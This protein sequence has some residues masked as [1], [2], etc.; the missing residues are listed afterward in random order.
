M[1]ALASAAAATNRRNSVPDRSCSTNAGNRRFTGVSC[2]RHTSG[3]NDPNESA[4][5]PA[6]AGASPRSLATSYPTVATTIPL[7][8]SAK[9]SRRVRGIF[10]NLLLLELLG[11]GPFIRPVAESSRALAHRC[12]GISMLPPLDRGRSP[13]AARGPAEVVRNI[14]AY[15]PRQP[16]ANRDG[17]RSAADSAQRRNGLKPALPPTPI[18]WGCAAPPR[19]HRHTAFGISGAADRPA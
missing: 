10:I 14:P 18:I 11:H 12:G 1:R 19:A 7:L 13:S 3:S 4:D 8:T 6:S 15:S 2:I 16:A 5:S 17:S 9:N